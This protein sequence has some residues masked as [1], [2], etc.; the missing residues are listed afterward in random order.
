MAQTLSAFNLKAWID[1]HRALLKP[2]VGAEMVWKD[3][4]FIVM[5][6]GGPNARRDFHVDPSDEFFFQLEGDMVLEYIDAAGKRQR[7]PIRQ[8]EVLL[9]PAHTPH[10]PQRPANSV[11]L[12]VE[13][14]R[15]ADEA[16]A[17][18]YAWYC[19]R[20]DAKLYELRRDA[21]DLLAEL[22]RVAQE[23]NASPARRTCTACGYVQPVPTGP[24]L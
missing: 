4:Q 18:A 15:G 5:V 6:I 23:F 22:T 20:C 1:E 3:S 13:R 11:G 14:V 7:A 8:G 24:R 17:E 12:V 9:L 10:S 21:E 19:E 2:P 16:K